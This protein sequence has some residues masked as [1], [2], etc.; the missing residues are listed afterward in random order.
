M[1]RLISAFLAMMLL[2]S[3]ATADQAQVKTPVAH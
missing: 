3:T 1:K 2:I